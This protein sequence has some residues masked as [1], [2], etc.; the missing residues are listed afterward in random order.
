MEKWKVRTIRMP[1]KLYFKIME[2]AAKEN[3]EIAEKIREILEKGVE[4]GL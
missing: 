4:N 1:N 3:K 2:I